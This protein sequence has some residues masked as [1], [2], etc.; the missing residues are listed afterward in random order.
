MCKNP[1]NY[2]VSRVSVDE[3]RA[4]LDAYLNNRVG[5][6]HTLRES[7]EYQTDMS[8]EGVSRRR[9]DAARDLAAY[10]SGLVSGAEGDAEIFDA[11]LSRYETTR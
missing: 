7:L 5:R 9:D 8:P 10:V 1:P 4:F 6:L 3:A 2:D 11:L